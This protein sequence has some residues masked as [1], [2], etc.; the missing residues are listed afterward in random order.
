MGAKDLTDLKLII[1]KQISKEYENITNQ[2]V[3]KKILDQLDKQYKFDLPKGMVEEEKKTV[4]H[5]FVHEKMGKMKEKDHSKII[6]DAK[7]KKEINKISERRV[8]AALILSHIGEEYSVQV[9]SQ[10]LQK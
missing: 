6:L 7:D 5:T 9:S 4:E 1:E 10:E 3:K 2:L 8:K